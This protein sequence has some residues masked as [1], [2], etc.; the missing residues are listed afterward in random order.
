MATMRPPT[1]DVQNVTFTRRTERSGKRVEVLQSISLT[2]SEGE[3]VSIVGPSGCGK[4]TLL[5]AIA[6][7]L[8]VTAGSI[9]VNGRSVQGPGPDR[10]CVFQHASLLPWRTVLR[11]VAFGLE[12]R[13][14][15]SRQEIAARALAVLELVGL[16]GH[17]GH[18]P[19]ELSGGMQ[20]RVNLARALV[21]EP[22][23]LLLD[24]PFAALD[25]Q[26]REAMQDELLKV[27]ALTKTTALLVTHQID[28]AVILS[29][30]VVVLAQR[31]AHVVGVLHVDLPPARS[32]A[33][34]REAGFLALERRIWQLLNRDAATH[35]EAAYA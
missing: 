22:S 10:A 12:L 19:H 11:N 3:L 21:M 5:H 18:Y 17:D 28:E 31:P 9:L 23:L 29:N 25:A 32:L 34:K 35:E 4:T 26:T 8:P 6:G 15:L 1:L 13:G 33:Q 2:M 14:T 30:R 16:R 24:E 20:Q 7:L 27:L